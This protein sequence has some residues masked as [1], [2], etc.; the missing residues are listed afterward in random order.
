MLN[1][2]RMSQCVNSFANNLPVNGP[3]QD[4]LA[5]HIDTDQGTEMRYDELDETAKKFVEFFG[6]ESVFGA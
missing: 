2:S 1:Y 6:R 3:S 4:D 5:N